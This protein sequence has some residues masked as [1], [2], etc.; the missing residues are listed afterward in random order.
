MELYLFIRSLPREIQDLI[1]EYNVHHREQTKKI[2]NQ[3]FQTIYN[4]CRN[5][6]TPYPKHIFYSVD[7]FISRKYHL[8]CYWCNDYCYNNDSDEVLKNK[9]YNSVK[10]YLLK[11]SIQ[12]KGEQLEL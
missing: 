7:Y 5:C 10:E 1:G 2:Q 3:F 4:P 11:H 8:T 6:N 9:Y 12:H